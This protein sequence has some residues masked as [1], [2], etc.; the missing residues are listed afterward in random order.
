MRRAPFAPRAPTESVEQQALAYRVRSMRDR[1]P[2]LANFTA[3]PAQG[4]GVSREDAKSHR[5]R[6]IMRQREGLEDGYPASF[7]DA[8]R[9]GWHGLRIEMKRGADWN[10]LRARPYARGL[11]SAEQVAWHQRLTAEGFLVAVAWGWEPAWLL[12]QWYIQLPAGVFAGEPYRL[13]PI[14][15]L[16]YAQSE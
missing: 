1:Y 9:G 12:I 16:R 13:P 4:G 15:R 7:L 8:A 10:T 14:P 5:M 3:F 6:Q 2:V 11:P